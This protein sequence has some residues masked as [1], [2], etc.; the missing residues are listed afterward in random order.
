MI[1]PNP[2]CEL[3]CRFTE[4]VKSMTCAYY[5]PMYDKHGNNT[6]PDMNTTMY[7]MHCVICQKDWLISEQL[8][9]T[10]IEENNYVES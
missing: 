5:P 2:T 1:N 4:G 7:K 8:G 9:K 10:T 6:N 3:D